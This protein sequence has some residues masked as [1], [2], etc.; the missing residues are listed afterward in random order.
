MAK[1]NKHTKF[2][3]QCITEKTRLFY[4]SEPMRISTLYWAIGS[5]FLLEEFREIQKLS[6]TVRGFTMAC[7][8]VD[9]G[10]GAKPGY[11]SNPLFTLSALQ[12]LYIL[13]RIGKSSP[14]PPAPDNHKEKEEIPDTR[15]P[16]SFTVQER[17]DELEMDLIEE[18][19]D[20]TSQSSSS[21]ELSLKGGRPEKT[22]NSV[23]C[24]AYLEKIVTDEKLIGFNSYLDMRY[25]CSYITSKH[26]LAQ[27]SLGGPEMFFILPPMKRIL[28]TYISQCI[29]IDG[30]IGPMPG[31]ESHAANTFC[32][33]ASLFLMG[34]V[35]LVGIQETAVSVSLLQSKK[36]GFSSR[37]DKHE[38]LCSTYW[39]YSALS[40]MGKSGYVDLS[41]VRQYIESCESEEG[42]YADRPGSAPDLLH[43]FFALSC[44]AVLDNKS[45]MEIL[46]SLSLC[47][48]D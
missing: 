31:C 41:S 45:L 12:I 20:N 38:D 25:I 15:R 35:S 32:G 44:F 42:G 4:L 17:I 28:C 29:N 39:A 21:N 27:L 7:Q 13:R 34:E 23:M 47:P 8:N 30:G 40:I 5:L 36:G 10:F 3:L 11:P 43:T 26:L 18:S 2:I 37:V 6:E 24:N 14:A 22:L 33:L 19:S 46:P 1:N 48:F 16:G 9:G